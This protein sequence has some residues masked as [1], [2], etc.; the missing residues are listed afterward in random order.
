MSAFIENFIV[1]RLNGVIPPEAIIFII[2]L[3]PVLELRG[4]IPFGVA[5]GLSP[6]Q[7]LFASVIGNLIPVPFI[8]LFARKVFSWLRSRSVWLD[9]IVGRLEARAEGKW[10]KVRRYENLGLLVLV[11][12]PLPGT[13]AWT[14][15]LI[16]AIMN[17]R[18]RRALWPIVLGVIIAG[19]LMMAIT[20][21]F[22]AVF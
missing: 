19:L 20:H 22:T 6:W 11:A 3:L 18:L 4:A 7:A 15:A 13:G 1:A 8:I 10:E 9:R 12:I 5:L 17:M 14:G 21:G 2:S 16:A